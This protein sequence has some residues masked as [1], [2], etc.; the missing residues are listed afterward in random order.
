[1]ADAILKY[2]RVRGLSAALLCLSCMAVPIGLCRAADGG[3]LPADIRIDGGGKAI[4]GGILRI[5]RAAPA[6]PEEDQR[7]RE[8]LLDLLSR[9]GYWSA[10]ITGPW[11]EDGRVHWRVA[12]GPVWN[13]GAISISTAARGQDEW[14]ARRADIA[15]DLERSEAVGRSPLLHAAGRLVS[16]WEEHG[17]PFVS[18]S[19]RDPDLAHEQ[20]S[21]T[22]EVDPGPAVVAR[23]VVFRGE[24]RTRPAFLKRIVRA[25]DGLQRAYRESLWE[26]GA[27]RLKSLGL[28]AGVAGPRLEITAGPDAAGRLPARVVYQIEA[29]LYN[30]FEAVAGYSGSSRT[31][32][33]LVDIGLGNLFGTGRSFNLVWERR[34]KDRTGFRL[35]YAEPTLW[36]LPLQWKV[37]VEHQLE[38]TL[39]TRTDLKGS[40]SW[41]MD[42]NLWLDV[43]YR[44]ER[45]VAGAAI[46]GKTS[47]SSSLFGLRW[48]G[49]RNDPDRERGLSAGLFWSTGKSERFGEQSGRETVHEI[50]GDGEIRHPLPYLGI[51]RIRGHG[52]G[53]ILKN[54]VPMF[55][56]YL[57]GGSRSLRGY[58][59]E[60][61][62]VTRYA[63]LQFEAG[64]RLGPGGAR[65]LLFVDTAALA[66][67]KRQDGGLLGRKGSI[68]IEGSYGLG[69]RSLSRRGL[70]RIDYGIP[71][72]ED[73]TVGRLHM[74][75][76]APF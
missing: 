49:L 14:P 27:G 57:V 56:T 37:E 66:P 44:H 4:R 15:A 52:A 5:L 69:I 41:E 13:F 40:V 63:V 2:L 1:M 45:N 12:P 25:E 48:E 67:W 65:F 73:P 21:L 70:V 75:I 28:F 51:G 9:D 23:E 42:D 58:R 54:P 35:R 11:K 71:W 10:E 19:F 17:H 50:G 22:L 6:G 68:E 36:K 60:A 39:F 61:F 46:G 26:R 72:G 18:V 38:D 33:G 20:L 74:S 32:S 34:E 31:L 47:R 29:K 16:F 3:V 53:R 59:E 24:H 43:G 64:P 8:R 76:N 55:E 7:K 62:R 30:R